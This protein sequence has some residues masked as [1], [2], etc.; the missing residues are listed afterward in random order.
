[1]KIIHTITTLSLLIIVF[2]SY[3]FLDITQHGLEQYQDIIINNQVVK[4]ATHNH[5][6]CNT[7][8][9]IIR[10]ILD[11]YTR[12][13]TMLDLGASQGYYSFRGAWDYKDS[14]FVMIEGNNPAYPH[15]GT[16]L[17]QLC[18]ENTELNNIVHLN[19][20]I[21]PSDIQKLSDCEHF[22]VVL[23][24][25]IVH[26]F[27]PHWKTLLNSILELGDNI[28][29]ETPPQESICSPQENQ[30]RQQII[31]C[32]LE[33]NSISIGSVPRHTSAQSVSQLYWV[34]G[35]KKY[36]KKR[37][38]ITPRINNNTHRIESSF[39][40]KKLIK[41][42]DSPPNTT[43]TSTWHPG[44]NLMT[45]KMYNGAF[46]MNNTI[47]ESIKQLK[48]VPSNDWMPNNM[49]IQGNK[50]VLIDC[51]DPNHNPGGLGG[52]RRYSD[53][54]INRILEWINI[55]NPLE[56]E[57]YFWNRIVQL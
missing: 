7:R 41:K 28:I 29:I 8:Y 4:P 16:Q 39:S 11:K 18:E 55:T 44:I 53:L 57:K 5:K 19:K 25:N 22:D 38:W 54:L 20:M 33:H 17:L 26:W 45:F 48:D 30:L 14:T 47:Q 43:I 1:M 49:I 42:A 37:N 24:L 21:I 12:P 3:C 34:Q 23:V 52:G 51:D 32:L 13:F 10:T 46:P 35:T 40:E 6:D 9:Q 15:T 27:K 31:N 2:Q 56:V 50:I 36:L